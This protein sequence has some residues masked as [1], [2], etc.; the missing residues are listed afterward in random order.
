[1][2]TIRTLVFVVIPVVC[3]ACA[4][5]Q[6]RT[7]S[8]LPE[9]PT[10]QDMQ[11][12]QRSPNGDYP[13]YQRVVVDGQEQ[14]C[15]QATRGSLSESRV[16]CLTEAQLRTEHLLA[17]EQAQQLQRQLQQSEEL[18]HQYSAWPVTDYNADSM[19][20]GIPSSR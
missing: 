4:T 17:Q 5:Q 11:R 14:F 16:V 9:P 1:M 8:A 6:S 15:R 2:K 13:G 19:T 18:W 10:A 3:A 12:F 20:A 7:I